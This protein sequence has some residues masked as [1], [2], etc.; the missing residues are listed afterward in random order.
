M[1]WKM[2]WTLKSFES[3]NYASWDVKET[4]MKHEVFEMVNKIVEKIFVN[5]F[6]KSGWMKKRWGVKRLFINNVKIHSTF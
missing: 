6:F 4:N 3:F 2:F 5:L 1:F